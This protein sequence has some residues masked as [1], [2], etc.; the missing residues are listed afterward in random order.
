MPRRPASGGDYGN[1]GHGARQLLP[2]AAGGGGGAE[3][4]QHASTGQF[5]RSNGN[6]SPLRGAAAGE[7]DD[8]HNATA[9]DNRDS[10]QH[11]TT[12]ERGARRGAAALESAA[13]SKSRVDFNDQ[14]DPR[15]DCT[16]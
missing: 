8:G 7:E 1:Y 4:W 2:P 16:R 14:H 6:W 9:P 13:R 3:G 12:A 10:Q 15:W 5:H 11:A